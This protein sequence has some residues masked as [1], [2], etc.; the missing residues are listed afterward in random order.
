LIL[1]LFLFDTNSDV[2]VHIPLW[3]PR[4]GVGTLF[5]PKPS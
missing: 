1:G 5:R 4:S 3:F 2:T